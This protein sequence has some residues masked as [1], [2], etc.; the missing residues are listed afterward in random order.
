MGGDAARPV[1]ADDAAERGPALLD[2]GQPGRVGVQRLH[3]GRELAGHLR[4][5][6]GRLR[7]PL[8][9]AVDLGVVAAD[10]VQRPPGLAEQGHRVGALAGRGRVPQQR[11]VRGGGGGVQPVGVGQPLLLGPERG[12][13]ARDRVELLDLDQPGPELGRLG[14]SLAGLG[15]DLGQL[16][17]RL[18]VPVVGPLV[19]RQDLG[20]HRARE[21]VER[22]PLPSGLEQLLLVGLAVHGDEVVGQV[23]EQRDRHRAAAGERART[24]LPRHRPGQHQ[25]AVLVEVA[26]G[27]LDL[28][29]DLAAGVGAEPS[30]DRGALRPRPDPGR[31]GAAAEEQAEAGDHHR[32]ARAGL[33]GERGEP[34]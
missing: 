29:R 26:A 28:L 13:L 20:Q 7:Q 17:P 24:P 14:G 3:V 16:G 19:V 1:Q 10:R 27:L 22:F 32:L 5:Q 15:G 6:V 33:A 2:G 30:L 12:G 31:V 21:L 25:R 9:D 4:E 8:G 18:P 11:L 23:G 34:G